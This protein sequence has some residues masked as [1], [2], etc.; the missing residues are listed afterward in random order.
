VASRFM[1]PPP[2]PHDAMAV[3]YYGASH[4]IGG[5]YLLPDG[6]EYCCAD[7]SLYGQD[8]IDQYHGVYGCWR[9]GG[10]G[11]VKM[12]LNLGYELAQCDVCRGERTSGLMPTLVPRHIHDWQ[13]SEDEA[14]ARFEP[15]RCPC[16]ANW[17]KRRPKERPEMSVGGLVPV[18]ALLEGGTP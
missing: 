12:Y 11:V 16:G 14:P 7:G 4:V 18:G 3:L 5:I 2:K 9:C 13:P 8:V 10:A 6:E 17:L 15:Q 1:L